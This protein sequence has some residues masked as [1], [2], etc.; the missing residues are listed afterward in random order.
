MSVIS[1]TAA[2][3]APIVGLEFDE[4]AETIV[5]KPAELAIQCVLTVGN[6]LTAKQMKSP[7]YRLGGRLY[8]WPDF[9]T[10]PNGI[11]PRCFIT[12]LKKDAYRS[13]HKSQ[14]QEKEWPM[15]V[16]SFTLKN[17]WDPVTQSYRDVT[18]GL[19][20][21]S[22][23]LLYKP[24]RP[25]Q[26]IGRIAGRNEGVVALDADCGI[27][28][29]A[30]IK[31]AQFHYFPNWLEIL[32]GKE[33]LPERL[34]E[35]EDHLRNRREQTNSPQLRAIGDAF[36]YSCVEF[37]DW[38]KAFR[39]DAQTAMIKETEGKGGARYSEVTER[40]FR[41]LEF[42]REDQLH[43]NMAR[44]ANAQQSSSAQIA[45]AIDLL[46]KVVAG[47]QKAEADLPPA[48]SQPP[49]PVTVVE[50]AAELE[51]SVDDAVANVEHP[52]LDEEIIPNFVDM[53]EEVLP[54][55]EAIAAVEEDED[56]IA[57]RYLA[58]QDVEVVPVEEVAAVEPEE[59]VKE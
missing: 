37:K 6:L 16:D 9:Y 41:E 20:G 27:N 40:L 59:E 19:D 2:A 5:A 1:E 38:A 50:A 3:Q 34:R 33:F 48:S 28:S 45:T 35:L 54:E 26:E 18:V 53:S 15:W 4:P 30:D 31:E 44:D 12:R 42:T 22:K 39:I 14:V 11:V 32:A 57:A 25:I 52:T 43:E 55:A 13:V 8:P 21:Y 46:A 23:D 10:V 51:R 24:I 58:E 36:L 29:G 17:Q 56:A 7:N 47:Q 49:A